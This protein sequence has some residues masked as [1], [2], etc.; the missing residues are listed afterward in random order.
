MPVVPGMTAATPHPAP[1]TSEVDG[2]ALL[3]VALLRSKAAD[4][5]LTASDVAAPLSTTYRRRAA[6]LELEA[7]A[8]AARFGLIEDL[9]LA[10]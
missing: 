3:D 7:A 6:E 5:R 10:A 8:L 2:R 1:R 4:L 9:E